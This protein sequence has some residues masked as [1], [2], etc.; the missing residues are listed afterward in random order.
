M[1]S[2][3]LPLSTGLLPYQGRKLHCFDMIVLGKVMLDVIHVLVTFQVLM[4]S[5]AVLPKIEDK[6][7]G[8]F[9]FSFFFLSN[10]FKKYILHLPF[11]PT[12]SIILSKS[13]R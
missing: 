10:P 13:S 8:F 9:L 1:T 12:S 2:D 6:L 5:L 4:K 3:A 11:F 7:I